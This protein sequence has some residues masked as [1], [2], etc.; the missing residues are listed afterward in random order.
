MMHREGLVELHGVTGLFH[1]GD[2]VTG[3]A[4]SK[5]QVSKRVSLPGQQSVTRA[6]WLPPPIATGKQ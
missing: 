3:L 2:G 5:G 6:F 4:E 1:L